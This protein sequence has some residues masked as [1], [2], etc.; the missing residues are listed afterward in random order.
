[1][2]QKWLQLKGDPM[3]RAFL[4]Q[5]QR[6]ESVFDRDLDRVHAV[7]QALMTRKGVFNV[8]IHYSSSRITAWFHDDPYVYQVYTAD[9]V[10]APHFPDS[11]PDQ[12]LGDRPLLIDAVGISR[13]LAE[14][15]RLRLTDETIYL[16]SGSIN[17]YNG[18]IVMSFSCDGT[19]YID[20]KTFLEQLESF[21]TA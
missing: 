12:S 5:Q 8:R 17:L 20:H 6:A 13:I 1:M 7:V 11:L 2:P 9:Q 14:F 3:V 19:H 15:K 18:T 10:L 16:R 4:F 21:Q